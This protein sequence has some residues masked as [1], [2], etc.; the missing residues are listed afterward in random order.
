MSGTTQVAAES[1]VAESGSETFSF[2]VYFSFSSRAK[3]TQT[4]WE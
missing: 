4:G 3:K 2:A 1:N